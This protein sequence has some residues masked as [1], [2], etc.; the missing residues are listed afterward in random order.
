MI[1]YIVLIIVIF[2]ILFIYIKTHFTIDLVYLWVDGSDPKWKEKKEHWQ[3]KLNILDSYA[4]GNNRFQDNDELKYSLR[5]VELYMPW[6]HRI[7]I[8]TDNQIPKWLNTKHPKIRIIDHKDIFPT[9]ALPIF[10]STA[11]EI[12][13]PFIPKLSEHFIFTN[14]DV[15]VNYPVTKDLLFTKFGKPIL[16]NNRRYEAL[17][18]IFLYSKQSQFHN[19]YNEIGKNILINTYKINIQTKKSFL[20]THTVTSYRK[21]SYLKNLKILGEK[22][23]K[24][25]YSKFRSI[26]DIHRGLFDIPDNLKHRNIIKDAHRDIP[27][28]CNFKVFGIFAEN[29]ED[30]KKQQPCFFC[31]NDIS[32]LPQ[33]QAQ[34]Q[35]DYLKEKYPKKSSFEK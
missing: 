10:N 16:Y 27:K 23:T 26:Y 30:I 35:I 7:F 2:G 3:R 18:K 19:K 33:E 15:F 25:A 17:Y 14:D 28:N 29:I 1:I 13:L 5:S 24:T 11:I 4:I 8:I 22:A 12:R 20:G 21:S 6:I 31:L 32:A 9:D 34:K